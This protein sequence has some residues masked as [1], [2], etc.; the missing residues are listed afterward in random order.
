M[1]LKMM[2]D[3]FLFREEVMWEQDFRVIVWQSCMSVKK[4]VNSAAHMQHICMPY[5]KCPINIFLLPLLAY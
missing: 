4:K 2:E 1:F 3:E 5:D